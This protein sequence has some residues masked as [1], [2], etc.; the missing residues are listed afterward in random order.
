VG[1]SRSHRSHYRGEYG[2]E[3]PEPCWPSLRAWSL[4]RLALA[5]HDFYLHRTLSHRGGDH[6]AGTGFGL[7][8]ASYGSPPVSGLVSGRRPPPPPRLYRCVGVPPT[9]PWLE[10]LLGKFQLYNVGL[11]RKRRTTPR[12]AQVTAAISSVTIGTGSF[13]RGFSARLGFV[14]SGPCSGA[15]ALVGRRRAR[16]VLPPHKFAINGHRPPLSARRPYPGH[17]PPTTSGWP[18]SPWGRGCTPTTTP[19]PRR[20]ASP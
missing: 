5:A 16:R 6:A 15:W 19:P 8:A 18:F 3:V 11:Y 13:R 2:G 1:H 7:A 17:P 4:A 12:P 14:F 20:P 10:G 9:P